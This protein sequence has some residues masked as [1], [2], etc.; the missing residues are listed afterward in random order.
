MMNTYTE[1]KLKSI[2]ARSKQ[3]DFH[4]KCWKSNSAQRHPH[5]LQMIQRGHGS[6]AHPL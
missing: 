1:E 6:D 4:T 2:A 5:I 3:S